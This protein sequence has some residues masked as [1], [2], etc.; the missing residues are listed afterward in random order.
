[1]LG[2]RKYITFQNQNHP[3]NLSTGRAYEADALPFQP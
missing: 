2:I 3:T 1:M